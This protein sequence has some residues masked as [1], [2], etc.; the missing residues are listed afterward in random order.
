MLG[1]EFEIELRCTDDRAAKG[2]DEDELRAGRVRRRDPVQPVRARFALL[3]RQDEADAR[4]LVHAS[5]QDLG[6]PFDGFGELGGVERRDIY[7]LG[8]HDLTPAW[9]ARRAGRS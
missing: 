6:E 8:F 1:I 4:A 5:L 3:E 2:R 9:R 7:G